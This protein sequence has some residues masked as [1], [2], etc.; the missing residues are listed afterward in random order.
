MSK[1]AY[2]PPEFSADCDR[3]GQNVDGPD[4]ACDDTWTESD[5]HFSPG[6]LRS[7]IWCEDCHE[8][9]QCGC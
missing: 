8:A 4:V 1:T 6:V 5:G 3:C 7:V 9:V 2:Y